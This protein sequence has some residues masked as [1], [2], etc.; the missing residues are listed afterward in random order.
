[1]LLSQA[2][3]ANLIFLINKT[4]WIVFLTRLY[5]ES[6]IF[7]VL[8]ITGES[9]SMGDVVHDVL[10]NFEEVC[11]FITDILS[12]FMVIIFANGPNNIHS[13]CTTVL[14]TLISDLQSL[15][16]FINLAILIKN[17]MNHISRKYFSLT[18][19]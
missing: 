1:M 11:R 12:I 7:S 9:G 10:K 4:L 14:D 8:I 5:S 19:Q 6:R 13:S 16:E 3:I 18:Y 17:L 15:S 2:E